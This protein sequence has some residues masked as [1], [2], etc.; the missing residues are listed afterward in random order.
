M[1]CSPYAADVHRDMF[2]LRCHQPVSNSAQPSVI[3]HFPF[4]SQCV[5]ARR[6]EDRRVTSNLEDFSFQAAENSQ[7][8]TTPCLIVKSMRHPLSHGAPVIGP[9]S[10][11]G[12]SSDLPKGFVPSGGRAASQKTSVGL[13]RGWSGR[14]GRRQ[15]TRHAGSWYA[16]RPVNHNREWKEARGGVG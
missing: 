16:P 6:G 4:S 2:S 12:S 8:R 11:L 5:G 9:D 3:L 14:V 1:I 15:W 7:P 13:R 10:I